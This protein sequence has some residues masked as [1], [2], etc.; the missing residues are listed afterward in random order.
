MEKRNSLFIFSLLF[1][2]ITLFVTVS[3]SKE[4]DNFKRLEDVVIVRGNV[5]DVEGNNYQT[6]TIGNQEWM[7]ENLRTIKYDDGTDIFYPGADTTAWKT[8]TTGAYAWYRDDESNKDIYGALYNWHAV[9]NN[10]RL[11]PADWRVPTSNDITVLIEFLQN[12]YNLTN[13]NDPERGLANVLKSCRQVNSPLGGGCATSAFPRWDS[14]NTNHGTD[15]FGFAA[16]P[17]GS[18]RQNGEYSGNPSATGQWWTST[19]S[20][21]D[22]AFIYY[23]GTTRGDMFHSPNNKLRGFGVRCVRN[24]N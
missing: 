16:L 10:S 12:E 13:S 19:V 6:V 7:A 17:A 20:N 8:S 2:G 3:C 9:T 1:I 15:N 22:S 5:N 11:C 14:D 21:A 4:E 24:T 18:R 23:I